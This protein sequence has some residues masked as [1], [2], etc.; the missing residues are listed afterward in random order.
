V[1]RVDFFYSKKNNVQALL[2]DF[3]EQKKKIQDST[4]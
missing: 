4:P 1:G 2:L 3:K